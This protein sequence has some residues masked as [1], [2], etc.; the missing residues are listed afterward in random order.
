MILR[1]HPWAGACAIVLA[2]L[3]AAAAKAEQADCIGC[4]RALTETKVVHAAVNMGCTTC[5][6]QLD[7]AVVPHRTKGPAVPPPALCYECHDRTMFEGKF[8][9]APAATGQCQTCHVPHGGEHPKLLRRPGVALCLDCHSEVK[10]APHVL[11]DFSGKGHPFG[12]A[13]AVRDPLRPGRL[14]DCGSCH[15]PHGAD[16]ARLI[17]FD[18]NSMATFCQKCHKY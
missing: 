16:Y 6:A 15:E 9:H 17:R 7:A 13:R 14:F 18:T 10:N 11:S 1:W 12:E 5:H 8:A 3:A 4:H 2:S